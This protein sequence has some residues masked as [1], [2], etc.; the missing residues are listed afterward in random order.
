MKLAI[1][2]GHGQ[3]NTGSSY[4]PGA[5]AGGVT[6]AAIALQWGLTL[7]W[8]LRSAGIET[9][10]TRHDDHEICPVGSRARRAE[11]AG[12]THFLAIH[13]N[14]GG[15][16]ASGT[17]VY[18]GVSSKFGQVQKQFAG[19]ILASAVDALGLRNRGAHRENESQH[20]RLAVMRFP[21]PAALVELGFITNSSDRR[22]MLDR[23]VRIQFATSVLHKIQ[24]GEIR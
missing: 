16:L 12:A 4:D 7:N 2:P 21:G 14:S 24:S 1:D 8:V 13:C 11:L 19:K 15:L 10:L 3:G 5:T 9:F 18:Y 23:D 6:E 17:E 22:K 20:P